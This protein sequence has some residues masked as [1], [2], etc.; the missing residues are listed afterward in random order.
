MEKDVLTTNP[1]RVHIRTARIKNED[2]RNNVL[3]FGTDL[4]KL[5]DSYEEKRHSISNDKAL[6]AE[7]Q[8]KEL[9]KLK[10]DYIAPL[11]NL[12]IRVEGMFNL[13]SAQFRSMV[14]KIGYHADTNPTIEMLR[15]SETRAK[16]DEMNQPELIGLFMGESTA[17]LVFYSLLNAPLPL[18]P[19]DDLER[20]SMNKIRRFDRE[21]VLYKEDIVEAVA[22]LAFSITAAYEY[23]N[24]QPPRKVAL[25]LPSFQD[26]LRELS[27][28]GDAMK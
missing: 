4:V 13:M 23:L 15:Q 22:T 7:G 14:K 10:K 1:Y 8:V 21:I 3:R 28:P 11:N 24:M 19:V 20:G 9:E 18:L 12:L 6:T 27:Y 5:L 17:D 2:L 26:L 25:D 16:L